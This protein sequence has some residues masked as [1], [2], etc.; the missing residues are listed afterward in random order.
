MTENRTADDEVV[1][2]PSREDIGNRLY[3][4][5][6]LSLS[7][8]RSHPN[9]E[10]EENRLPEETSSNTDVDNEKTSAGDRQGQQVNGQRPSSSRSAS[11]GPK[12]KVGF[13]HPSVAH[14]RLKILWS[15]LKVWFYLGSMIIVFFSVYWGALY[16][17]EAHLH[18]LTSLVVIE[19]STVGAIDGL[20]GQEIV[21]LLE[22]DKYKNKAGWEIYQGDEIYEIFDKGDNISA[23]II[24]K[25][26]HHKYWSAVHVYPN[27]TYNMYLSYE[28]ATPNKNI[29][30]EFVYESGRDITN[31]KT[32][33]VTS[34][35]NIEQSFLQNYST[36]AQQ[37][38]VDLSDSEKADLITSDAILT[39]PEFY[40]ND[41]RPYDNSVLLA[42]L[43][44]GLIYLI[45][46]SFFLFNFFAETHKLL[47]PHVKLPQYLLYRFL[48]NHLSYLIISIFICAVSAIFQVDF[49]VT[50]GR[51][52]FVIY[53]FTTYLTMAAVGGANENMAMLIFTY[54]PPFVSFW[55]IGFVIFNV[56]PSFSSMALINRFYRYGYMMPI[57]S[58]QEIYKVI[59]LNLW[60]GQ[61]GLYY[62]LLCVWIVLNTLLSPLILKHVG[63]V[64]AKRAKAAA[65]AQGK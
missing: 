29:S 45:I 28:N 35:E 18:N 27:A 38:L 62:G 51:A 32:Y 55:L 24:E 44:V 65:A 63:G 54:N 5:D 26:H 15:F 23:K 46:V 50:F 9:F 58:A 40:F 31:M 56:S 49:T 19:D 30:V 61:L 17:R 10:D 11:S 36:I 39:V 3:G 64:M 52:G 22:S 2:T 16:D 47:I 12:G 1:Y 8:S 34:F 42:P 43:Q 4:M 59:F 57:H 33:V 41:Y 37:L 21:R 48:G 25:V 53:W 6:E 14:L 20:I 60:K 7:Y 13:F